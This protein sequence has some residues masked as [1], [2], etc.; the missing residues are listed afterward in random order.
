MDWVFAIMIHQFRREAQAVLDV[1]EVM[2]RLATE[3]QFPS[4]AP[5]ATVL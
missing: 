4:Y 2:M 1:A 5:H 3:Q